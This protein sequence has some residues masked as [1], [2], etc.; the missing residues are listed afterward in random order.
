MEIC[1]ATE[2]SAGGPVGSS[3]WFL[4]RGSGEASFFMLDFRA[5][6]ARFRKSCGA[7]FVGVGGSVSVVGYEYPGYSAHSK[8]LAVVELAER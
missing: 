6:N 2:T 7:P 4:Y 1:L 5:G 8:K 3:L